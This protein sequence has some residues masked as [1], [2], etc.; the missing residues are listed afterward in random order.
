MLEQIN[1]EIEAL[2]KDYTHPDSIYK[3]IDGT[4]TMLQNAR[5]ELKK[6]E[7]IMEKEQLDVEK[8]S[9]TSLKTLFYKCLGT[10]DKQVAKEKE[11]AL[12]AVLKYESCK[13][14]VDE[15]TDKLSQL[16]NRHY[17]MSKVQ[18]KLDALY[19]EKRR[20]MASFNMPEYAKIGQLEKEISFIRREI[21]ELKEAITPGNMAINTLNEAIELLDSAGDWG[22][23]D[24]LGGGLIADMMKHD[25]IDKAKQAI[26]NAQT[27][28]QRLQ[29]ELQDVNMSLDGSIQITG[30]AVFAD[31]FFDGLIADWYMQ[32][33]ISQSR[34]NVVATCG[35]IRKIVST[36]STQLNHKEK[37]LEAKEREIKRI[38]EQA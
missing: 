13:K 26:L 2:L 17:E 23:W 25:K 15:L 38:I 5:Y 7:G 28:V 31:F 21:K 34:E 10:H 19:E 33:K 37:D 30:G 4:K 20:V 8:M 14:S 6:L 12:A 16:T 9:Q 27:Y 22:T 3:K 18:D 11:E 24:L 35:K 1:L 32:S 29:V 36:L